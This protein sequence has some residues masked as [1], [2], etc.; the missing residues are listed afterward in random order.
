[1]ISRALLR[2]WKSF[3]YKLWTNAVAA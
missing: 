1:V 3:F 2:I